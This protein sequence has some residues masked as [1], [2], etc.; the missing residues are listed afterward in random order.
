MDLI[1]DFFLI[2]G[3]ILN[4]FVLIGLIRLKQKKLSQKILILFWVFVLV[5][6]LHSYSALHNIRGLN[7]ITFIFED[8]SRFIL[9]PLIYLYFKSLFFKHT[10]FVKKNLAHFIPFLVYFIIYTIPRFVNIFT[11]PDTF[12][13]LYTIYKYVN[14]ALVKDLF[15]IFYCVLSLKLFYRVKKQ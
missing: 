4:L 1:V 7:R 5:N 13:H 3:I 9:A 11:E 15:F 6:I 12:T 2:V 14:L 10:D 8:G